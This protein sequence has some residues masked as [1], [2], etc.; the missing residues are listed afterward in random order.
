MIVCRLLPVL[1][2]AIGHD[3]LAAGSLEIAA[4]IDSAVIEEVE[5]PGRH[6]TLPDLTVRLSLSADC[7]DGPGVLSVN[8][9]D[10]RRRYPMETGHADALSIDIVVPAEQLPPVPVPREFCTAASSE[11]NEATVRAGLSVHASLRCA[12]GDTESFASRSTAAD[13][14]LSCRRRDATDQDPADSSDA[15]NSSVRDQVS[16][17]SS[18]S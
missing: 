13:I 11:V 9:A 6:R 2:V 18:G 14:P 3:A 4:S 1:A 17:A 7:P 15:R 10:T 12:A 16:D 5:E 8:V